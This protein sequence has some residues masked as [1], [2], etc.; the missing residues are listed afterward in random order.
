MEVIGSDGDGVARPGDAGAEK[1]EGTEDGAI[2]LV[3]CEVEPA[4]GDAF[5][6]E[7]ARAEPERGVGP[8]AAHVQRSRGCVGG[9]VGDDEAH[10]TATV[11]VDAIGLDLDGKATKGG[12][13]ER[14]VG[15]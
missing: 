5:A 7:R 6:A 15:E 2:A 8:V 10:R 4:Y 12:A 14:D 13:G 1:G 9:P 3:A 11:D